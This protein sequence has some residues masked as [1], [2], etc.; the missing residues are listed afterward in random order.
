MYAIEE[1]VNPALEKVDNKNERR[2]M[3]PV[4]QLYV[5]S[6]NN[7]ASSLVLKGN[8]NKKDSN[9]IMKVEQIGLPPQPTG[10]IKYHDYDCL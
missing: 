3:L 7:I 1:V 9:K 5:V 6:I 4:R 10:Y 8:N 2:N